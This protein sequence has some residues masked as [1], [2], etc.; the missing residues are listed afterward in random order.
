MEEHPLCEQGDACPAIRLPLQQCEAMEKAFRWPVALSPCEPCL[1]GRLLCVQSACT[2]LQFRLAMLLHFFQPPPQPISLAL[3]QQMTKGLHLA[4]RA[5]QRLVGLDQPRPQDAERSG[6]FDGSTDAW[7]VQHSRLST[8]KGSDSF[9]F[10]KKRS[11]EECSQTGL[12]L[13]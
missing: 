7:L 6:I 12:L 5:S 1:Y 9:S 3:T 10:S 8:D 11:D 2:C 13:R 4:C